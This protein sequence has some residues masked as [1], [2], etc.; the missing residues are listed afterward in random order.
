MVGIKDIAR[1]ANVSISTVSYALNGSPRVSERTRK[2]IQAI[3]EEMNYIP[4]LAGV[5]MRSKYT[6]I[7]SVHLNSFQGTFYGDLLDGMNLRAKEKGIELIFC[8]GKQSKLFLPQKLVDGTIILDT[9]YK[10]EEIKNFADTGCKIVV[11]DREFNHKNVSSV[12][13][14]NEQGSYKIAEKIYKLS[15]EKLYIIKGPPGNFDSEKRYKGIKKGAK[16]F[17]LKLV[18]FQGNYTLESGEEMSNI[19]LRDKD[20]PYAVYAFND[21]MAIGLHQ[22]CLER[23]IKINKEVYIFGFDNIEIGK[24]LQPPLQSVTYSKHKWG[25]MAVDAMLELIYNEKRIEKYVETY[26]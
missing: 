14:K 12:L 15:L 20:Y 5:H 19:I 16:D 13:L 23:N 3:A 7:V 6:G 17:D 25:A 26:L 21:E 18:E 4:N 24:F 10:A 9:D 1:A 2:M 11:L 8:S 22:K